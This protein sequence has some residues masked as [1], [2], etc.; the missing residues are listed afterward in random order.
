[1]SANLGNLPKNPLNHI[2]QFL[3]PQDLA[4][5]RLVNN[6]LNTEAASDNLYSK[7]DLKVKNALKEYLEITKQVNAQETIS[8]QATKNAKF[9]SESLEKRKTGLFGSFVSIVNFESKILSTITTIFCTIFPSIKTEI[10]ARKIEQAEKDQ[11]MKIEQEE[12]K[13]L[14]N[15]QKESDLLYF[16]YRS[17]KRRRIA[18]RQRQ[19]DFKKI[20]KLFVGETEYMKL[21]ELNLN[22]YGNNEDRDYIDYIEAKDMTAPIMRGQD[23]HGRHFFTFRIEDKDYCL[24][25]FQRYTNG[26]RWATAGSTREYITED[27]IDEK[28][29]VGQKTF[30][31]LKDAIEKK[32]LTLGY[33]RFG[34]KT[35][36]IK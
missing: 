3:D 18:E 28:G 23:K 10:E 25:F 2:L 19:D 8:D 35:F 29:S 36:F 24:T 21:P 33:E 7:E 30:D 1:M 16:T 4:H 26:R 11:L 34:K 32:T 5:V 17:E 12:K 15:L 20:M 14:E 13:K 27:L 9:K 31:I 6:R 22:V